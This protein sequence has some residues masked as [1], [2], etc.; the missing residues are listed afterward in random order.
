MIKKKTIATLLPYKDN[1]TNQKAGSASI[2][3]KDFNKKSLFKSQITV[4][5]FSENLNDLI[6]KKN[7]LNLNFNKNTFKSKNLA[8]VDKFININYK[9]KFDLVEVHNR[10]SYIHHLLKK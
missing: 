5:G 6:D 2:W 7:Y 9:Y 10:P 8:Y 1:F 3:I 4:C